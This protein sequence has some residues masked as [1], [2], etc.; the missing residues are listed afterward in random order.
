M[1]MATSTRT[2]IAQVIC[3]ACGEVT[4]RSSD[5]RN[6]K[7]SASQHVVPLWKTTITS[8]L[9]KRNQLADLDG[10]ISGSSEPHGAGHMCRKC[11]YAYE[12]VLKAKAIIESSAAKALDA[13]VNLARE[14]ARL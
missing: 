5:R 6:L 7:S 13:I 9:Q 11:F 12:K 3:L 14:G 1:A 10:L 8:E 4:R 2:P